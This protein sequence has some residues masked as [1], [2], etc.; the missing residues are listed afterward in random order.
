M[1]IVLFSNRFLQQ[2]DSLLQGS[3]Y[4]LKDQPMLV[5]FAILPVLLRFVRQEVSF[6][7]ASMPPKLSAWVEKLLADPVC[8]GI[9]R[10]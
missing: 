9:L 2:V 10:E 3:V 8:K 1:V 5:D 6:W 7:E 4:L